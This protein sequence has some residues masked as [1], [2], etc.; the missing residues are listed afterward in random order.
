MS[1]DVN[2]ERIVKSN[3]NYA[4]FKDEFGQTAIHMCAK[5]NVYQVIQLLISRLGNVDAQDIY[6]RTPLMCAAE[7][8]HLEVISVLLLN[9]AD[10]NIQDNYG[11][12]AIDYIDKGIRSKTGE[13]EYKIKRTLEFIRVVYLFNKMMVNEKDFDSFVRNS[14]NYLFKDEFDIDFEELLR[15][16]DEVLSDEKQKKYY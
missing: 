11:K 4:L 15:I 12:R 13:I 3:Y 5:R 8:K 1:L 10:P 6:G 14:I 16:N 2:I 9:Y 7:N